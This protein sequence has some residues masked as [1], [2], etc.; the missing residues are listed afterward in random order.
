MRDELVRRRQWLS[1]GAFMDAVGAVNLIPGP[2]STELAM[3]AGHRR[4]GRWGLVAGGAAFILPAAVITTVLAW[5]Y[6]KYG[7]SPAADWLLYGVKPVMIA[8]IAVAFWGLR[9]AALHSPVTGLVGATVLALSLWPGVN[10]LVL[11]FAGGGAALL[12]RMA[13]RSWSRS[14]GGLLL[15]GPVFSAGALTPA[16]AAV[17]QP[18]SLSTLFLSF[19]KIGAVL[20][21]SGYVL[22]AFVQGEF[23]TRLGWLT[24]QQILDAIAAGQVTPGPVFTTAT[25]IGYISGGGVPGAVLATVG[26]FL[27]SFLF[28][29]ALGWLIPRIRRNELA[30]ATLDGVNAASLGLMAA[31]A[32]RLGRASVI[33]SLTLIIGLAALAL[34]LRTKLNSAWLIAAGGATGLAYSYL[35]D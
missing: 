8:V 25:F 2:N 5:A 11:L 26:I 34:L 22:L 20:Y 10:E 9:K 28:V 16:L 19:L 4:A 1:D 17:V 6:V 12:V 24:E 21:G 30:G 33:D 31:V 13:G 32:Y 35:T 15:W 23:V 27:P 3:H 29:A 14:A 18:F 7:T